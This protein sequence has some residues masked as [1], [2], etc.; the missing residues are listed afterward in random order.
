M[1]CCILVYS[2]STAVT[3]CVTIACE[4]CLKM[5]GMVCYSSALISQKTLNWQTATPAEEDSTLFAKALVIACKHKGSI[6][7][8]LVI[9]ITVIC[10]EQSTDHSSATSAQTQALCCSLGLPQRLTAAIADVSAFLSKG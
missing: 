9:Q 3:Q 4:F 8:V 6:Q 5:N 1:A 10:N 2:V 7:S